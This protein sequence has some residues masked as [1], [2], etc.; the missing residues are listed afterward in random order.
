MLRLTIQ[1]LTP[2]HE[3]Q[4]QQL[5]QLTMS[6]R[7]AWQVS[8]DGLVMFLLVA[9]TD[10]ASRVSSAICAAENHKNA[11]PQCDLTL[12][13]DLLATLYPKL[14]AYCLTQQLD[15]T[16][17]PAQSTLEDF[18][19]LVMD[20][21]STLIN[22][23]CLDEM[24]DFCGRKAEVA[25]MT[26]AA[27]RDAT[28]DF[29]RSLKQ[30][31][32]LLAGVSEDVLQHV[33]Q[34]RLQLSLGAQPLLQAVKKVGMKTLL[35]SGGF[36]FFTEKLQQQ[37]GLDFARANTLE[38]RDGKLTGKVM[39]DIVDA[40]LKAYTV[41]K[42]CATLNISPRQAIVIGDGSNDL[43]MMRIA[44]LSVAFRAK[45]VVRARAAMALNF[46]GLDGVLQALNV[47]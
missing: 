46:V 23:E 9:H 29:S 5:A 41:E 2:L 16:L 35:V 43:E 31:L 21:D 11:R 25:A 7:D 4:R 42:T 17:V 10:A 30:R 6:Q 47:A 15:C 12:M 13:Q 34:E 20:M 39:G 38:V 1:G 22:I 14:N 36:T 24:A 32:A 44:G 40:Q 3:A 26:E 8:D 28:M 45:P 19:L 27:M 18:R 33:Y 37:L